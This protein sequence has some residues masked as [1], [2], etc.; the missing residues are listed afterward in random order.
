MCGGCGEQKDLQ[1]RFCLCDAAE[2]GAPVILTSAIRGQ[3][4]SILESSALT[5]KDRLSSEYDVLRDA[6]HSTDDYTTPLQEEVENT[7]Q[8]NVLA[9]QSQPVQQ[10]V[11]TVRG[12][13][14]MTAKHDEATPAKRQSKARVLSKPVPKGQPS[15]S[16]L[17]SVR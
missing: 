1:F 11:C 3:I 9:P 13:W 17:P 10:S 5:I 8:L 2:G 4:K 12:K 16:F 14:G 6:L 15:V 7:S